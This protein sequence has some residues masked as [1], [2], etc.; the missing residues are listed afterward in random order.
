M[1]PK[2]IQE[3]IYNFYKRLF[4]KQV[5]RKVH[6]DE[7]VWAEVGRLSEGDNSF[8]TRP[9][10]EEEVGAVISNLKN[11]SALGPDG[12]S[13]MFYK[14]CWN[15]IKDD[16]MKLV[17][18][19][20]R[21]CLDLGRLNY[22]AI[23]LIPKVQDAFNVKQFRPIC[24]LNVSFKIFSNLLMNRLTGVANKLVDKAQTAFIKGRYILDGVVILHETLHE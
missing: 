20:H 11:N 19:F 2:E 8:L 22:G 13:Y 16:F 7:R 3:T 10:S 12:F 23:T 24:L 18:D 6:L 5:D 9:F 1:D 21:G 4:G 15:T 17:G 14:S